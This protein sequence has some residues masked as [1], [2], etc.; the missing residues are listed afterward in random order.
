MAFDIS[1]LE[2]EDMA[3]IQITN[4]ATG[5]EL[6]VTATIYGQDSD[7]FRKESHK[8]EAKYTEYS[9]RNRGKF[10]PP[11]DRERLDRRKVIACTKNIDGLEY[12]GQALTDIEDIYTRFPWMYEQVV[13]A[14]TDRANFIKGSLQK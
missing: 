4:P 12:K 13:A 9:R 7:V 2:Q 1:T 3:V 8:A 6:G 10:M 14:I 11:E 5:D